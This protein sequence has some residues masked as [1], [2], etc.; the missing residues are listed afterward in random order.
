MLGFEGI[1][2]KSPDDVVTGW[3]RALA[4][5]KPVVVDACTDPEVP[6]LPPHITF[7]QARKYWTAMLRGDPHRWRAIKQSVKDLWG[8]VSP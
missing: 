1:V 2:M 6:P 7:E 4:A 5:R 8:S 3:E